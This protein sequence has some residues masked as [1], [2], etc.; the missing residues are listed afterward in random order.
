MFQY[1]IFVYVERAIVSCVAF[2]IFPIVKVWLNGRHRL[3][4]SGL[5]LRSNHIRKWHS[6]NAVKCFQQ[7]YSRTT[8]RSQVKVTLLVLSSA[9][10]T[11]SLTV[12]ACKCGQLFATC[13]ALLSIVQSVLLYILHSRWW[14]VALLCSVFPSTQNRYLHTRAAYLTVIVVCHASRSMLIHV[15]LQNTPIRLLSARSKSHWVTPPLV[16]S[17]EA[18]ILHN[19]YLQIPWQFKHAVGT[20]LCFWKCKQLHASWYW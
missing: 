10:C 11:I 20:S 19:Y 18:P 9:D 2:P 17:I 8:C 1:T 3:V 5:V 16:D 15:V 4:T 7:G 6:E 14:S 13:R 12:L